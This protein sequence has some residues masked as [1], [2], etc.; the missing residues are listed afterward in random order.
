M[1]DRCDEERHRRASRVKRMK[2]LFRL[3]NLEK[4]ICELRDRLN[5]EHRSWMVSLKLLHILMTTV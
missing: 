3:E 5:E 1:K 4:D 2:A